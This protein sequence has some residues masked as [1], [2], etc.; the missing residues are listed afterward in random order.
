MWQKIILP[1][2]GHRRV[3]EVRREDI[4][5]IHTSLE[6]TPYQGNRVLALLADNPVQAAA[7]EVGKVLSERMRNSVDGD[8]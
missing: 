1:K 6:K 4:R 2:L 3:E 8:R 5:R 7:E